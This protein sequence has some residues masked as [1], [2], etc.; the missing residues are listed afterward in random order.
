MGAH[1]E[2]VPHHKDMDLSKRNHPMND[3][4][5][6]WWPISTFLER[7]PFIMSAVRC[8]PLIWSNGKGLAQEPG[9]LG[10]LQEDQ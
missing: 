9:Q 3:K 7:L 10:L 5:G 1:E 4:A 8:V 6:Q 2:G